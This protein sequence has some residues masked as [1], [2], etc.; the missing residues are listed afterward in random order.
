LRRCEQ[1]GRAEQLAEHRNLLAHDQRFDLGD[2][3]LPL[4]YPHRE[5][6]R[7][8]GLDGRCEYADVLVAVEIERMLGARCQRAP[9]AVAD[10][11]RLAVLGVADVRG[12]RGLRGIVR[13]HR[14]EHGVDERARARIGAV[15]AGRASGPRGRT[16]ERVA[17]AVRRLRERGLDQAQLV[18]QHLEAFGDR[19]RAR[20]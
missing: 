15:V 12:E 7:D 8:V 16:V 9:Q 14:G 2:P 5:L 4:A 6:A 1:R 20:R 10:R 19:E 11:E 3:A 18:V 13:D 17:H